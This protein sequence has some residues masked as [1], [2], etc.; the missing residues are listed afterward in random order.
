MRADAALRRPLQSR[1]LSTQRA[2]AIV[3]VL[4]AI[5]AGCVASY[6]QVADL[7]GLPRHARLVARVLRHSEHPLPWFRVVRSDGKLAFPERSEAARRQT[8]LL[9]A[10]GIAVQRHRVAFRRF[11][12]HNAVQDLGAISLWLPPLAA[13]PLATDRLVAEPIGVD[14][15]ACS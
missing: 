5:P 14:S 7:A 6:G 2:Q 15:D 9:A 11:G 13:E 3:R 1:T 8:Q 4:M 12:W 10:D